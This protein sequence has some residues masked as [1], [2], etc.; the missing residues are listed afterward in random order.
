MED[1]VD[2][3]ETR[4]IISSRKNSGWTPEQAGMNANSQR[5]EWIF[6]VYQEYWKQ[7][8]DA[9]AL[10]FDDLLLL[11]K[12]LFLKSPTIRDKRSTAFD[13]I[14]VDEAQDTNAIQFELMKMMCGPQAVITF[15]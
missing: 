12:A 8:Q 5:E 15:I 9:N 3:K 13:H 4:N 11:P 2:L 14:L 6:E 1:Y 7:M 10:D